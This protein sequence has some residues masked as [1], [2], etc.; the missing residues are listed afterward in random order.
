MNYKI[1]SEFLKSKGWYSL[2]CSSCEALFF[3]KVGNIQYCGRKKCNHLVIDFREIPKPKKKITLVL[4]ARVLEDHFL[5]KDFQKKKAMR[6]SSFQKSTDLVI[7]G[8]QYLDNFLHGNGSIEPDS[9]FLVQPCVRMQFLENEDC[10]IGTSTSLTNVCTIDVG[11][12]P[13]KILLH[14]DEWIGALSKSGIHAR[15]LSL[16]WKQKDK[17]WGAGAFTTSGVVFMYHN[18]EIGVVNSGIIPT[19]KNGPISLVESGFG[20]E[21]ILWSR[22]KDTSYFY[23]FKPVLSELSDGIHDCCR[24]LAWLCVSGVKKAHT[25]AGFQVH[26]LF[27]SLTTRFGDLEPEYAELL[28]YYGSF[29]KKIVKTQENPGSHKIRSLMVQKRNIF[30]QRYFSCPPAGEGEKSN[31]Y[32]NRVIGLGFVDTCQLEG[33][34]SAWKESLMKN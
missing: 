22:N 6:A 21:R 27:S 7:A 25:G 14:I 15:H 9:I 24:S 33:M 32:L 4:L 11:K 12:D 3:N 18:L 19:K 29:W 13:E 28:N 31:D 23:T 8:V 20:L 1:V 16:V 26:R 10:N 5:A 30:I 34:I 2:I 17:D